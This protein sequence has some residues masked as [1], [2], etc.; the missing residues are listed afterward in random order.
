MEEE[1]DFE[2]EDDNMPSE[3][4]LIFDVG[5]ETSGKSAS[6]AV[7]ASSAKNTSK[8]AARSDAEKP[9]SPMANHEILSSQVIK[10]VAIVNKVN[11]EYASEGRDR[12]LRNKIM[13]LKG[14]DLVEIMLLLED[15][16]FRFDI[17]HGKHKDDL[18]ERDEYTKRLSDATVSLKSYILDMKKVADASSEA[19]DNFRE[20]IEEL[21]VE[22]TRVVQDI[23]L[24][25]MQKQII[26]NINQIISKMP[27]NEINQGVTNF[28]H[29][30]KNLGSSLEM[31]KSDAAKF[32]E[33]MYSQ[34]KKMKE[35]LDEVINASKNIQNIY[36]EKSGKRFGFGVLFFAVTVSSLITLGGSVYFYQDFIGGKIN[37]IIK[38]VQ[39]GATGGINVKTGSG[40]SYILFDQSKMKVIKEDGELRLYLDKK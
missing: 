25:P 1:D 8:A 16:T 39:A 36:D 20:I 9:H 24:S 14:D 7:A 5:S 22:V 32:D 12:M 2:F 3:S 17:A 37:E 11:E 29:I 38:S 10:D 4:D 27:I 30:A 15:I 34:R 26:D 13:S 33:N 6:A 19:T 18:K 23:D 40:G 21:Q 31:W 35:T 28:I